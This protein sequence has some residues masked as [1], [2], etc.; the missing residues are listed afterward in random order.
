MTT[1]FTVFSMCDQPP[2]KANVS[3]AIMIV[4]YNG[5]RSSLRSHKRKHKR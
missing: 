2:R 5:W 4:R 1:E 3:A